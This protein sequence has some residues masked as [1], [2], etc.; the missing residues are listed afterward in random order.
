M[1]EALFAAHALPTTPRNP[2]WLLAVPGDPSLV[3][4]ERASDGAKVAVDVVPVAGSLHRIAPQVLLDETAAYVLKGAGDDLSFTTDTTVDHEPPAPAGARFSDEAKSGVCS[5]FLGGALVVDQPGGALTYELALVGKGSAH[6]AYFQAA[7]G[8][9]DFGRPTDGADCLGLRT[10][11]GLTE[12][13]TYEAVLTAYDAAGNAKAVPLGAFVPRVVRPGGCLE[14]AAS[15][16]DGC[17][18]VTPR[19]GSGLGVGVSVVLVV[20]GRRRRRG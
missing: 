3:H 9:R 11:P 10:L 17:G 1:D 18:V 5:P 15:G 16:E 4:L 19:G 7:V 6:R 20:V 8:E 12:G 2:S 14:D 13:A